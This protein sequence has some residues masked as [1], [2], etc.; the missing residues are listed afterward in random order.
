MMEGDG[1][2]VLLCHTMTLVS[3]AVII[4]A[5]LFGTEGIQKVFRMLFWSR[6]PDSCQIY[7]A[8][9]YRTLSGKRPELAATRSH[10]WAIGTEP[11]SGNRN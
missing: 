11:L 7:K 5:W 3:W 2:M 6:S 4:L 10:A 8:R 1:L 9:C